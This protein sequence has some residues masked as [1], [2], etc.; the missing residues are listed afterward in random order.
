MKYE[1]IKKLMDDMANSKLS[2]FEIE[3]PDGIKIKMAKESIKYIKNE[4]E[5]EKLVLTNCSKNS[6]TNDTKINTHS[7]EKIIKSP[8][9]GMFY[10]RPSQKEKPFVEIG[11]YIK[12]GMTLC[13]IEAMKLMNELAS[14]YDGEIVEILAKDGEPVEYGQPLFIIK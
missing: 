1:D 14:D 8:M 9:V 10:S 5:V 12:Q 11:N 7:D 2:E 13:I 6:E 3:Y 4:E